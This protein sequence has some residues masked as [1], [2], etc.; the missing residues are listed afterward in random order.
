MAHAALTEALPYGVSPICAKNLPR[1]E[2]RALRQQKA[3]YLGNFRR[4]AYAPHGHAF[5]H[6]RACRGIH[7]RCLCHGG[8]DGAGGHGIDAYACVRPFQRQR[9]YQTIQRG[10]ACGISGSIWVADLAKLAADRDDTGIGGGRHAHMSDRRPDHDEVGGKVEI[11]GLLPVLQ[12]DAVRLSA[13]KNTGATRDAIETA[14]GRRGAFGQQGGLFVMQQ[15]MEEYRRVG[16]R[17]AD[18]QGLGFGLYD[19]CNAGAMPV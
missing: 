2:R 11:E 8:S 14:E 10:L 17:F 1:D 9:F 12:R 4:L 3:H 5:Y 16:Y 7:K 6:R 19:C 18:C 15:I 13:K